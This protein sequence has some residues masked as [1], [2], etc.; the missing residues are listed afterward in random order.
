[1]SESIDVYMINPENSLG[2]PRIPRNR[3]GEKKPDYFSIH[4][5]HIRYILPLLP[6]NLCDILHITLTEE[7]LHYPGLFRKKIGCSSHINVVVHIPEF[8]RIK[9][10][11]DLSHTLLASLQ[12]TDFIFCV[13]EQIASRLR[14]NNFP[15]VYTFP[16]RDSTDIYSI[17]GFFLLQHISH[18]SKNVKV[19]RILEKVHSEKR[20]RET[21]VKKQIRLHSKGLINSRE[22]NECTVI[23]L[24]KNGETYIHQFVHYYTQLGV[25]QIIFIDNGST[26]KTLAM[27][28]EYPDITLYTTPLSFKEYECDIRREIINQNCRNKW[29]L[30]V[31]IDE[32]FDYPYSEIL[33]LSHF[34][35]YLHVHNYTAVVAHMLD[36]FSDLSL[37]S[38]TGDKE[39]D[40]RELYP[41]YDLSELDKREYPLHFSECALN[42]LPHTDIPFFSGGVR[43]KNLNTKMPFFLIKHPLLFIDEKIEPFTHPHFCNNALLAD[44]TCLL[45]HYKFIHSFPDLVQ[46][47]TEEENYPYYSMIEYN[48]YKEYLQNNKTP[49]FYSS[50]A[51]KFNSTTDLIREGFIVVSEAYTRFIEKRIQ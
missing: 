25:K 16:I 4:P 42:I 49:C 38:I 28:K 12:C 50:D 26:D 48:L 33:A 27:I 39:S 6:G 7:T 34:L 24:V 51:Q 21:Y 31:D 17:Y 41:Y 9:T 14:E 8:P 29:C 11:N 22:N 47:V 45:K 2:P 23:C 43:K 32:L 36:M 44:V 46:K 5:C 40:L 15:H 3:P 18:G 20:E 37:D 19:N 1:M 10:D 35:D 30:C 13:D